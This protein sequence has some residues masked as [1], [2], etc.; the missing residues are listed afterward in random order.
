MNYLKSLAPR[1]DDE[2]AAG[3]SFLGMLIEVLDIVAGVWT[4]SGGFELSIKSKSDFLNSERP[5]VDERP[6]DEFW[7]MSRVV[8]MTIWLR[9][10]RPL[11]PS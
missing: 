8:V 9:P 10:T 3:S 1:R 4:F 2:A 5:D 11:L 6:E 7:R